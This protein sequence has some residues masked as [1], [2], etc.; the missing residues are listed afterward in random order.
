MQSLGK[1]E[2]AEKNYRK[3][4]ELNPNFPMAHF[5]LGKTLKDQRK[6]EEA[7]A[8]FKKAISLNPNFIEAYNNVGVAM[9][10]LGK[11]DEAF[12]A[13]TRSIEINPKFH[14]AVYNLLV[15]LTNYKPPKKYSNSI[16][17]TDREIRKF[18]LK[19]NNSSIISDSKIIDLIHHST[20]IMKK[21]NLNLRINENQIYKRNSINLNCGRHK[22]IFNEFDII[23]KF[24]FDCYKVQVEPE[25]IIEL[26]KLLVVF[27]QIYLNKNNSRKCFV[28][29]RPEISGFY[30]GLIFCSSLEE[31][32]QIANDLEK[33]LKKKIRPNL[34][35][36]VKRGCSEYGVK[37]SEYK[38]I[39]KS[40]PQKMI[41]Q[42]NWKI[43]E[44]NFDSKNSKKY[45]E[46]LN[47][48]LDG[49][50]FHDFLVIQNWIDYAKGI[51]DQNLNEFK[52]YKIFSREVY[53][54]AKKRKEELIN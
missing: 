53:A 4:I 9:Q 16:I 26:I 38:L 25:S 1:L 18:N 17:E 43:I 42:K 5:N 11:L 54:A 15:L 14:E 22:K 13:F 32:Y 23:P 33:I 46:S 12:V 29:M 35:A 48:T 24:C 8:S 51:N 21:N 28:E 39:N 40:G 45:N 49:L 3:V 41:Y 19:N 6:L 37:F 50:N 31:A 2:E 27:D 52:H 36:I 30:K 10:S 34:K 47:P 44:E 7:I 20:T